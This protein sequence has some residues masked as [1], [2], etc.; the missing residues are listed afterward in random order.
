MMTELRTY[1]IANAW[2]GPDMAA[3]DAWI[4][5]FSAQEIHELEAAAG[6]VVDRDILGL[7]GAAS[8]S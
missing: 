3:S 6:A 7:S 4:H 2:H 1:D 8:S 5:E